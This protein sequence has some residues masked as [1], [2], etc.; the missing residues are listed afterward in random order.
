VTPHNRERVQRAI[1]LLQLVSDDQQHE[2]NNLADAIR[3]GIRSDGIGQLLQISRTVDT[4]ESC[5]ADLQCLLDQPPRLGG[6][7]AG[8]EVPGS[9]RSMGDP[10]GM[11]VV[12]A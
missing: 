12:A 6:S 9:K 1:D 8:R 7:A 5:S 3:L 2:L 4:I 10:P 11:G